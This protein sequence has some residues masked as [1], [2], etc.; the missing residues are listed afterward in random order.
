MTTHPTGL[1]SKDLVNLLVD[2]SKSINTRENFQRVLLFGSSIKG[3]GELFRPTKTSD[4]DLLFEFSS[5]LEYPSKRA[6]ALRVLIP[7]LVKLE[8]RLSECFSRE[9]KK[10][11]VSSGATTPLENK[12]SIN[13]KHD[14]QF[15]NRNKFFNLLEPQAEVVPLGSRM[16]EE[17]ESKCADEIIIL[18]N[19]QEYRKRYL[20]VSKEGK[21][22]VEFHQDQ[23]LFPKDLA[24]TAARL[25]YLE[26][27]TISHGQSL[28]ENKDKAYDIID[29]SV[30]LLKLL[31]KMANHDTD[32]QKL[33]RA[34]G[35]RVHF[36]GEAHS[37]SEDDLLVLWEVLAYTAIERIRECEAM[38]EINNMYPLDYLKNLL[39]AKE[40]WI[41][42]LNLRRFYPLHVKDLQEVINRK[43][44]INAVL[45]SPK[46]DAVKYAMQ[47]DYGPY[48][49]VSTY[50]K[51]IEDAHLWLCELRQSY[52]DQVKIKTVDFPLTYGIDAIDIE[53]ENGLI[54]VRYYPL[55]SEREDQP[56]IVLRPHQS[57]WYSFYKEQLKEKLWEKFAALYHLGWN[58]RIDR[59]TVK[60]VPDITALAKKLARK[61]LSKEERQKGW[62]IPYEE[63]QYKDFV[64]HAEHFY[65]LHFGKQLIGFVL[66]HSN[67]QIDRFG[68]EIYLHIKTI[69]TPP[70][71]VVRQI[72]IDP[73]FSNKKYGRDLYEFLLKYSDLNRAHY[74]KAICFIWKNPP[75]L[76][77][78]EF[79]RKVN[80]EESETY[81]LKNGK[82]VAGIWAR[83]IEHSD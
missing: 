63:T 18:R 13:I 26:N 60:L 50:R 47:Q 5:H 74:R 3:E 61:K 66:A 83:T 65:V 38:V 40:L 64:Q 1:M 53:S 19:C 9:E 42:G 39:R 80:W 68:D 70:F 25:Q 73:A 4:I 33:K 46:S 11:I 82:G 67:E 28:T 59:A 17:I 44:T 24:R 27:I 10:P 7:E 29:G 31:E 55:H 32:L 58:L 45:L 16:P 22:E 23:E 34:I 71:I 62:L 6:A 12:L 52:P 8:C 49:E 14:V 15:A 30:Y 76:G 21:R 2:W 69:Q 79:H 35:H 43:G 77:S 81:T 57:Y 78:E 51:T 75:N 54:Y 20:A 56:I 36:R 41:T 72:C 37:L 48:G